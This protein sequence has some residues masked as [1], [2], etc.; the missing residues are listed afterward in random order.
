MRHTEDPG[1]YG[2]PITQKPKEEPKYNP[3]SWRPSGRPWKR[4]VELKAD[5]AK[6]FPKKKYWDKKQILRQHESMT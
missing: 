3:L 2:D 5:L 6:R 4:V 1:T